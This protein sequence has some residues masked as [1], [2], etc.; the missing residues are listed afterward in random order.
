VALKTLNTV[1]DLST[2]RPLKRYNLLVLHQAKGASSETPSSLYKL[3][4]RMGTYHT[5][6]WCGGGQDFCGVHKL[7]MKA[8][9]DGGKIYK[10]TSDVAACCPK[11]GMALAWPQ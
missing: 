7:P 8:H 4:G 3:C 11:F 10:I 9:P 5:G 2:Y 1:V 6:G